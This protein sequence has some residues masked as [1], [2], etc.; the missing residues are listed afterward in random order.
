MRADA[1]KMGQV[2]GRGEVAVRKAAGSTRSRVLM[3]RD[4]RATADGTIHI[5]LP[6]FQK[7][8][9]LGF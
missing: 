5:G 6:Y 1:S 7:Q 2:W 3:P 4:T 9:D 8:I